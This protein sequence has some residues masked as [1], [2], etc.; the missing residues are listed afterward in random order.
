MTEYKINE[1]ERGFEIIGPN[2]AMN[3]NGVFY[4][5]S[6]T[7]DDA[8]KHLKD[9]MNYVVKRGDIKMIRRSF[10]VTEEEI[11]DYTGS[12]PWEIKG[13]TYTFIEDKLSSAD[14]EGHDVVV[15]R[16]SDGKF[17]MF[18]WFLSFSENYYFEGDFKE[19]F[20]KE[21]T[22]TVYE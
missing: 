12:G 19:V 3:G 15:K 21:I 13:E 8:K 1:T 14:G 7:L 9:N 5:T 20:P 11:G 18:N 4:H 22:I 2:H 6:E 17:F 10:E 16:E